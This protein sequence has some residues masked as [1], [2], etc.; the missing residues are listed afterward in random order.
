MII[1][2]F[3]RK[4]VLTSVVALAAVP[5]LGQDLMARQAPVDQRSKAV[6]PVALQSVINRENSENP[7]SDLYEEWE[8][9]RTHA[10]YELPDV[11]KI[12]LQGFH[13]PTTSRTVTSEFGRRWGRMH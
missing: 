7:S 3:I 9:R 1:E 12:N 4:I 5:A 11:Y 8:N 2:K 6:D 13:M 10:V